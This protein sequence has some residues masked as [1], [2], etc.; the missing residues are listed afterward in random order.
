MH[1]RRFTRLVNAFSK[2]LENLKAAVALYVAWHNLCR[3]HMTLRVTP[4]MEAG[5]TDH[6][7]SVSELFV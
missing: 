2:K 1:L 5:I 3:V 7:W 4:A 6:V